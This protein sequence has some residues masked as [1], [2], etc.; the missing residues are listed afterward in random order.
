MSADRQITVKTFVSGTVTT[1]VL[2]T[3]A[4]RDFTVPGLSVG[5]FVAVSKPSLQ[6][7]LGIVGCRVKAANTLSITYSN[8]TGSSIQPADE[9]YVLMIARPNV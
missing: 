6:A 1:V 7:G 8:N 9:T 2:N 5:D 3:T 4:E